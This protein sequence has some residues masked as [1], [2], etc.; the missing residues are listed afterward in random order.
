MGEVVVFELLA[1][2]LLDVRAGRIH[3]LARVGGE[4]LVAGGLQV[5]GLH[6]LGRGV[7]DRVAGR[8][9]DVASV[10]RRSRRSLLGLSL[11][12]PLLGD[13]ADKLPDLAGKLEG[14]DNGGLAPVG[15]FDA[16]AG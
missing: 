7:L 13:A 14:G 12:G 3:D 4:L 9:E 16:G 2:P 11:L 6:D 1:R 5:R 10:C 15:V 8:P